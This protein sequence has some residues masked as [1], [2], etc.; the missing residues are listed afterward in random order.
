MCGWVGQFGRA[1]AE[2]QLRRAGGTL[3]TRGPDGEGQRVCQGGP[4]PYGVAH[5]RLSILDISPAGAQPMLAEDAG[6]CLAYNGEIYN[7]P[8]L[9]AELEA[10]GVRFRSRSD[11]EVLLRGWIEWGEE[12]LQRIEGIFSFAL[13]DERR[14]RVLMARD[15]LG[16]KPLYWAESEGRLYAGSAPRAL[17]ALDPDLGRDIDEVALAQFLALLW[18]PHPRTPWRQVRKLPP[19]HA[20]RMDLTGSE[21]FRYWEP[22]TGEG[23][24][25]EPEELLARLRTASARQLLSDVPVGVLFSGGLDSTLILALAREA[26]RSELTAYTAGFD[27]ES[28]RLEITPDDLEYARL[29]ARGMEGLDLAEVVVD[30]SADRF[31]D[32]LGYHFDDPVAEPMAITLHRICQGAGTKVL[33]SGMGGEELFAGYPR[34]RLLSLA[35]KAAGA[36]R[37]L[38]GPLSRVA[39]ALSGARPGPM[40]ASRRNLQK[41]VRAIGDPRPTHYWRML[42][43]LTYREVEA[44]VPGA[45]AEAWDELDAQSPR[46]ADTSL[47]EAL[48]FDRAQFL[49]NLNLLTVDKASMATGVELRV[50]LLDEAVVDVVYSADPSGFV[51]SGVTKWPL[52]EAAR[53]LIPDEVIDRPKSGFSAP[54]RAWFQVGDRERLNERVEV[55]V[56][57]GLVRAEGAM[58]VLRAATTGRADL[59]LAAWA[60][61]CLGTWYENH[62]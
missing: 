12:V 26:S 54:V 10:G 39:G 13:V 20:I 43:Q 6:V 25:I 40:H 18:I 22:P 21:V 50:P 60:L 7:S 41:L 9:R 31:V 17:L 11:T 24:E 61:V 46:L 47:A 32:E 8:E 59:A 62:G 27:E 38:T 56:D 34:H 58:Q 19:G 14:G 30:S 57:A 53:G 36:P 16:V 5:R 1:P 51:R 15:R 28:R 29:V 48:A 23:A 35:R 4:I 44:L 45:A 42:S 2:G 52:K 3:E 37:A 49:P 55:A 33:L